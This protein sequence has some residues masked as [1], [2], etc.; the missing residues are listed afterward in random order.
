MPPEYPAW[1]EIYAECP[2]CG[3]KINALAD[4]AKPKVNPVKPRSYGGGLAPPTDLEEDT[5]FGEARRSS[6]I[7]PPLVEDGMEGVYWRCPNFECQMLLTE[8]E[9]KFNVPTKHS[10]NMKRKPSW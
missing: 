1:S 6:G 5:M 4:L 2:S 9:L 8:T 7:A 10:P 3:E